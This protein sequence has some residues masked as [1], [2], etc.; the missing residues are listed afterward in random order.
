MYC[1]SAGLRNAHTETNTDTQILS[2][3]LSHSHTHTHTCVKHATWFVKLNI[4]SS[5]CLLKWRRR[6][7]NVHIYMRR[8]SD[9]Y[10]MHAV[11]RGRI[12]VGYKLTHRGLWYEVNPTKNI[13]CILKGISLCFVIIN[14]IRFHVFHRVLSL[15]YKKSIRVHVN[16]V[17]PC[18]LRPGLSLKVFTESNQTSIQGIIDLLPF[19]LPLNTSLLYKGLTSIL[20]MSCWPC[21]FPCP[22]LV[23]ISDHWFWQTGI[24]REPS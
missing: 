9:R 1:H 23:Q 2:L 15:V 13:W 3:S 24:A 5:V 10:C 21:N 17:Q 16:Y 19:H 12:E 18:P 6:P 14:K 7:I 8:L 20:S 4:L 11:V 22:H